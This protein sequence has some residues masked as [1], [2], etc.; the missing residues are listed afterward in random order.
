[1]D[2]VSSLRTK[3][4]D[5]KGPD[6]LWEEKVVKL[7]AALAVLLLVVEYAHAIVYSQLS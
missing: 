3:Y 5:S 7:F 2:N 6:C 1:M 4:F